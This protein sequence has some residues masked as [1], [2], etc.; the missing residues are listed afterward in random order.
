MAQDRSIASLFGLPRPRPFLKLVRIRCGDGMP[1]SRV[2]A[3]YDLTA[4]PALAEGD[5]GGSVYAF[6]G[7]HWGGPGALPPDH[8]GGDAGRGGMCGVSV[9]RNPALPA[10]Q[11]PFL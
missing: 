9:S 3:W 5:L 2:V 11:A 4:V 1:L 8:R 10:D 6:L 7:A